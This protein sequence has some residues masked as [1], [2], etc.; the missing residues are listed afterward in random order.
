[1]KK[2][3]I[4]IILSILVV[5]TAKAQFFQTGQDPSSIRWKQI[6][7][8]N[9]QV[10]Y[11]EE[12]E[13]QAQRL[14][15]VLDKVYQYGSVTL[16]FHPRK[17]SVI[18]HTRTVNSNGLLGWAP[19]RI[20]LFT[21]P[22]QQIY[23]QDWLEELALH[24][25]RHLVQLDKV[26]N[27][28]PLLAK[29]IL[30][31]QA[32][33]IVVGTYL[34][35]WFLEG[36]AVVT[37]T[38]LSKSGRGRM[39]SFSMDYRAQL[40]E[41]G[42]YSFDKAYLGSYQDFVTDHYK[43]GYWMVGKTREKYG[44]EIWANT[45]Q[46]I[47]E[48]PLSLTPVNSTLKKF[49]G[50]SAKQIYSGIFDDLIRDWKHDMTSRSIDSV[51]VISPSKKSFTQY[52]Y[53]EIYNDS[54]LFAYRTAINDIGRFVLIY[55]DKSEKVI[56]T[57]GIIFEES[58]SMTDNLIIW[59]EKRADIRWTHSDRSVIR[60][61]NIQTK[62]LREIKR[63]HK[64]FSPVISPDLKSFAA[65]EIDPENYF[66]LSVFDLVTGRL[67]ERFKTSDNQYFFTPCWD[68]KGE[69]LF[70][71]CLAENG[72][73]LASFD[74]NTKKLRQL[75]EITY[76]NLKNPV[77][78]NGQI[79]FSADFSGTDNL[80][81][82]NTESKKITE[83]ASVPFGADHPCVSNSG[84]Q[85]FFSN[86]HSGGYQ[87][88][89]VGTRKNSNLKEI[90][91]IQLATDSFAENLANQEKG[92]PD[93]SN[94]DSVTYQT[95]KYSKL[96]HLFNFHSWAPAYI[97][98]NSYEIRPGFSLFSQNKL[99]TAETRLG[100][101]YN[102]SDRTGRYKLG[103]N[104]LGWFPEIYTE[105]SAGNEA[106]T[107]YQI[108][109]LV[110]NNH[111]I[112]KSDTTVERFT[113]N[114]ISADVNIRLPLNF[115]KGKYSRVFYP[116]IKYSFN[117]VTHQNSTPEDFYSGNYH[118]LTYRIYFYNLLH[119]SHQNLMP[120]WGQQFDL[121]FR[122]TPF[123]GNDLGTLAGIQSVLYFPGITRNAGIKIYQGYQEKSFNKSYNF[124]NFIRSPRG[125]S[126]YQNNKM[127][128]LAADY[129]FPL[130][131]PDFSIGKLAYIKRI[132]TSFFYDYVWLSVPVVDENDNVYPNGH[133]F[134]L[135]SYGAELTSDLHVL[136]FFAPVE[137][138]CRTVYLPDQ[139]TFRFEVLF[140]INFNGF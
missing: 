13:K 17:V 126:G 18:L 31:E 28:L 39:A 109:N 42:K 75:T 122:H 90:S 85:L 79:I 130:I 139:N 23:A 20:E 112:L 57:P 41:K 137:L 121:I 80:Y 62:F 2:I 51:S 6:N 88:A 29:V 95:R 124:S 56:Y 114:E 15:F 83:V 59:A 86:Y 64:L 11:P 74:L 33:A 106:S 22:H 14:S 36:D 52:L 27:E 78:T 115:S 129:K 132:K 67:I 98:V 81:S 69:K 24:E 100:Y 37:E 16:D 68:E 25:F 93:F 58:V 108:K 32:T 35:L 102:V 117:Q 34:P 101:D 38:A 92:L 110:N 135:N 53:P 8:A 70:I 118:A 1:M 113:W 5:F 120:R 19:K 10:V 96:G 138:G 21:T 46:R 91:S 103:F 84:N 94:P 50:L 30:G 48:H 63:E 89:S 3:P 111:E 60:V 66:Y 26:E 4:L 131:Y 40:I 116:E 87:L 45:L 47:G 54:I 77:F 136:R 72:K 128:S 73:Y 140:S 82:L 61:Y 97:D 104:Y 107:F 123:T 44:A 7:T 12:F 71:V 134:T 55:P 76:A 133:Q 125:F 105:F 49:S 65:I 43:L 99:G 9:F 119:Q 127:Y